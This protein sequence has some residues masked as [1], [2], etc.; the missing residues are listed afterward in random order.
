MKNRLGF[1]TRRYLHP[2]I[3]VDTKPSIFYTKFTEHHRLKP[4]TW[5]YIVTHGREEPKDLANE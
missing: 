4:P 2:H 1:H 3:R 5:L